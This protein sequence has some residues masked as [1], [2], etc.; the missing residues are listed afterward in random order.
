[1]PFC[2]MQC[3]DTAT[4]VVMHVH[5]HD[6]T[7]SCCPMLAIR[8]SSSHD[9]LPVLPCPCLVHLAWRVLQVALELALPLVQRVHALCDL[10]PD[11]QALL[12]AH[13]RP[14]T[15]PIGA[16]LCRQVSYMYPYMYY[17]TCI[18]ILGRADRRMQS[19]QFYVLCTFCMS[20]KISKSLALSI[21]ES[22]QPPPSSRLEGLP[23]DVFMSCVTCDIVLPGG[24]LLRVHLCC[25][26]AGRRG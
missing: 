7:C 19:S 26:P 23:M 10:Y 12:A 15:M 4:H 2:G 3:Y 22:Q 21:H 9:L 13:V 8:F 16:E 18:C 6:T 11:A 5:V 1:M 14:V 20:F 17:T 25:V 24:F